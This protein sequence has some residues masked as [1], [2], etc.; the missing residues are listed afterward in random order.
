MSLKNVRPSPLNKETV[1]VRRLQTMMGVVASE[2]KSL[3]D[4]MADIERELEA[5]IQEIGE[6][7]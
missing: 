1:S 7:W 2:M 6:E 4:A 5:I 3:A